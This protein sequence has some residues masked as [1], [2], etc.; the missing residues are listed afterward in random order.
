MKLSSDS[1]EHSRSRK[2]FESANFG[3]KITRLVDVAAFEVVPTFLDVFFAIGFLWILF[4][5]YL[6]LTVALVSVT[7]LWMTASLYKIDKD[8]RGVVNKTAERESKL[9]HSIINAWQ[10][11]LVSSNFHDSSSSS[12]DIYLA[13]QQYPSQC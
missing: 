11:V 2:L 13:C 9:I 5:I 4:D 10:T 12:K 6:A 1:Y 8:K 3:S 7:Y